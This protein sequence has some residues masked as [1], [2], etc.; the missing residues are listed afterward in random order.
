MHTEKRFAQTKNRG[1]LRSRRLRSVP[2]S[3]FGETILLVLHSSFRMTPWTD[4]RMEFPFD[5]SVL[6]G[7]TAHLITESLQLISPC[8]IPDESITCVPFILFSHYE[9][10]ISEHPNPT[11][12]FL[13]EFHEQATP[14]CDRANPAQKTPIIFQYDSTRNFER[15]WHH[16]QSSE[17]ESGRTIS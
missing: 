11:K 15:Q 13:R 1:I 2:V 12:W 9:R 3:F 14:I 16:H 5:Q 6:P 7:K 10:S 17:R 4:S 8:A